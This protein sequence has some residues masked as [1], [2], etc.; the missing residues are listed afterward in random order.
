MFISFGLSSEGRLIATIASFLK[1]RINDVNQTISKSHLDR[2]WWR[3]KEKCVGTE[4]HRG[5]I[6]INRLEWSCVW[7]WWSPDDRLV[8]S[9][10]IWYR[11]KPRRRSEVVFFTNRWRNRGWMRRFSSSSSSSRWPR[12]HS[13]LARC[14]ACGYEFI[15]LLVHRLMSLYESN[16]KSNSYHIFSFF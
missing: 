13:I 2:Y 11:G 12:T 7:G 4:S 14:F 15:T 5:N 9:K 16:H 1:Y 8:V 3:L 6:S 10:C